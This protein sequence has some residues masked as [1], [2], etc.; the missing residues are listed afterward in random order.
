MKSGGFRTLRPAAGLVVLVLH[1]LGGFGGGGPVSAQTNRLEPASA[2]IRKVEGQ[3]RQDFPGVR[4]HRLGPGGAQVF[5]C[6]MVGGPTPRAAAERWLAEYGSILGVPVEEILIL[7]S[8]RLGSTGHRTVVSAQQIIGGI[9]VEGSRLR[10]LVAGIGE[11]R[12]VYVGARTTAEVEVRGPRIDPGRAREIAVQIAPDLD[13]F[14]DPELV[15]L[16]GDDL[17][18]RESSTLVWKLSGDR[19]ESS[20]YAAR[21]VFIDAVSGEV[22][23]VRDEVHRV[24]V[25]GWVSGLR[26]PGVSPDAASSPPV[27]LPLRGARVRIPGGARVYTEPDGSFVLPHSGSSPVLVGVD[28]KGEWVEVVSAVGSPVVEGREVTPP[29]PFDF[30]LNSAPAPEATA[31]LNAFHFTNRAHDFFRSR[32]PEFDAIDLQIVCNVNL[33][34]TCNAFYSSVTQSTNFFLSGGGCVNSAYSSLVCH[35]YGHFIVDQLGLD[36]GAFGEGFSDAFALLILDDPVFGRDFYGPGTF[37]RDPLVGNVQYPCPSEDIHFCGQILSGVWARLRQNL[38]G[39]EGSELGLATTQQLFV[40]WAQLTVG[41]QGKNSAHLG[42]AVELLVADDDDGN[43]DSATPHF[44]EICAAF[45]S[46][47]IACP[48]IPGLLFTPLDGLPVTL[49]DEGSVWRIEVESGQQGDPV[50]GTGVLHSRVRPAGFAAVAMTE[51]E[52]N[53]YEFS[54]PGLGCDER[55]DF[56]F[57]ASASSGAVVPYPPAADADP[58]SLPGASGLTEVLIDNFQADR[59][60]SVID[61]DVSEGSWIRDIP[62]GAASRGAPERDFDGSGR[63]FLT[64]NEDSEAD[65]DGGPTR[66]LSPAFDLDGEDG[67]ISFAY[68]FSN[69]DGD[70]RLVVEVSPT[71]TAP[72]TEVRSYGGGA[73]AWRTDRFYVSEFVLPGS[74]TRISFRAADLPN[75]SITEAAV[76]GFSMKRVVCRAGNL[77]MTQTPLIPGE[78][79]DFV[80][81]GAEPHSLVG[82]LAGVRGVGE[83]SCF[84]P[85]GD[86]CLDLLGRPRELARLVSDANG[87]ASISLRIPASAPPLTVITQAVNRRGPGGTE[88]TKTSPEVA[89]VGGE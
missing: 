59:G 46:H 53:V 36:Q 3:L 24:D 62:Q 49:S 4:V 61:V 45:A 80:V 79:T 15:Y 76:D 44:S 38:G 48:T 21:S 68:W 70:D 51:V 16:L 30:V 37:S 75:N 69:D 11:A 63:C 83:G 42:T 1:G 52:P 58:L 56:Y 86:L 34:S 5:G 66:L 32:A 71:G 22:L 7:S 29:G 65:L 88:S 84:P 40:D 9:P 26:S 89:Q 67:L 78:I 41:G 6:P 31:Q 10:F 33:S 50:S 17:G 14:G 87:A 85:L 23:S 19:S 54:L 27:E 81:T 39:S 74:E 60:W 57:T 2:K 77:R 35:E 47:G 25:T 55:L 43:L 8:S 72:W 20:D 28:L 18:A 12:V 82:I 73:P 13:R 64:G